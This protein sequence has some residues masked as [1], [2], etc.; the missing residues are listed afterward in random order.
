MPSRREFLKSAAAA[1][2]AVA[3]GPAIGPAAGTELEAVLA[4]V[5]VLPTAGGEYTLP[6]LPYD[7]A[8]LEPH[9]D[10]Q[11]MRIHHD[12]HHQG[13]VNGLN[14]ALGKLAG[15]R[16]SGDFADVQQLSR[17]LAFHGGGHANHTLFWQN[18][19]PPGRGGGG[20]PT[21]RIAEQIAK[22]FGDLA[23][24]QAHFSAAAAAVEGS[25]WAVLGWHPLLGRLLVQTMM[26]QQNL[27]VLGTVPLLVLDVWEH[28][29]YLKYQNRRGDYV[30]AWWN[31][32]NWQDAEGRFQHATR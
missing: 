15:A 21:G 1:G 14:A 30:K 11:T 27:T 3:V 12:K 29:Y 4:S 20:E 7:Y 23:R 17:L 2:G 5:A 22:D 24:F 13:Y 9:I 25:G 18:M 28:A 16:Q 6:P 31:V 8:S 10:E 26:N 19:A 32:V